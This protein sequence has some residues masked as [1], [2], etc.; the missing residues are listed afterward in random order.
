MPRQ[1]CIC[2][3]L[4]LSKPSKAFLLSADSML[5]GAM[6]TILGINLQIRG[7]LLDM[8]NQYAKSFFGLQIPC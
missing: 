1:A 7:Q 2:S 5:M 8:T 4:I 3:C 6:L